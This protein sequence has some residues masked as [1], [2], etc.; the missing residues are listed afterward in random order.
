LLYH[1]KH[2]CQDLP[3]LILITAAGSVSLAALI[4]LLLNP[5]I[6]TLHSVTLPAFQPG[7]RVEIYFSSRAINRCATPSIH[8]GSANVSVLL[9][10]APLLQARSQ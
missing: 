1:R 6:F 9:A 7:H 2:H 3:T 8:A 4:H 5:S 10:T